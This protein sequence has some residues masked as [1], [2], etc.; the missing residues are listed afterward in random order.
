[1]FDVDRAGCDRHP[2]GIRRNSPDLRTL[3]GTTTATTIL[4]SAK[5]EHRSYDRND[6]ITFSTD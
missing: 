6:P 4:R 2:S 3:A 5:H 1:M